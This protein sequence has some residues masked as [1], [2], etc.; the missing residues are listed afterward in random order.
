MCWKAFDNNSAFEPYELKQ[1]LLTWFLHRS[2]RHKTMVQRGVS[3]FRYLNSVFITPCNNHTSV[4]HKS[5][6]VWKSVTIS[7]PYQVFDRKYVVVQALEQNHCWSL[8]SQGQPCLLEQVALQTRTEITR[9]HPLL[10]DRH[11]EQR[12]FVHMPESKDQHQFWFELPTTFATFDYR[13]TSSFWLQLLA[14]SQHLT[15]SSAQDGLV[16]STLLPLPR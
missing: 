5:S 9:R 11:Q 2:T 15:S 14:Q 10:H 12:N 8:L 1:F 3:D 6:T 4:V 13:K 7:S 16:C